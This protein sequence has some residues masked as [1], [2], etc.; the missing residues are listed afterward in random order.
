[1]I[2]SSFSP[3]NAHML[4]GEL[5]PGLRRDDENFQVAYVMIRREEGSLIYRSVLDR[6]ML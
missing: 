5:G 2:G 1:M 3:P 6:K 4:E